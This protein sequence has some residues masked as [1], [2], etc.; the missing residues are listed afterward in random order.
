MNSVSQHAI[1]WTRRADRERG[2]DSRLRSEATDDEDVAETSVRQRKRPERIGQ[3]TGDRQ[4]ARQQKPRRKLRDR[5]AEE[6][7]E[8]TGDPDAAT[9]GGG[10]NIAGGHGA[11]RADARGGV[12]ARV[13]IAEVVGEITGDLDA[14]RESRD[15][16][17]GSR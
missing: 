9:H 3:R 2:Q 14:E 4:Q 1:I 6:K 7:R 5:R 13:G 11:T 16:S 15:S 8:Q 12:R 17:A 10:R